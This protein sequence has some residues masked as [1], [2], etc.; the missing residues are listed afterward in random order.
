MRT[1]NFRIGTKL[2]MTAGVGVILVAGMLGNEIVGNQQIAESTFLVTVNASNRANAQAADTAIARA[3]IAIREIESADTNEQL[4]K[5]MAG[6][7][8]NIAE[9][10]TQIEAAA[11]RATRQVMRDFYG[12]TRT[13][14]DDYL[15]VCTELAAVQ[16][17]VIDAV[18]QRNQ[19]VVVWTKAFDQLSASPALAAASNRRD[20][21]LMLRDAL[22]SFNAAHGAGWRF[23]VTSDPE[24]KEQVLRG[25]DTAIASLLRAKETA[26][27]D[28]DIVA[29]IDGLMAAS[30]GF[31]AAADDVVKREEAKAR[32]RGEKEPAIA[33]TLRAN[34]DKAV[35]VAN[36]MTAKRQGELADEITRVSRVGI[37]VGLLVVVVLI[38]AAVFSV[39]GVARPIRRIGDVLLQLAK[40]NDA[41]DIPYAGRGDEI[42]D[43]ARAARTFR[44]NVV[45]RQQLAETIKQAAQDRDEQ[46][47]Q[48]E[49][50]VA[51]F[52]ATADSLLGSVGQNAAVMHDT[53][54]SLTGLAGTAT[55]QAVAAAAASEETAANVQTVAAATE[56]LTVSIQEIGR[57]VEQAT[58]VVRNAGVTTD[59]SA[60]EIEKLAAS[61][62]RIGDV[63][64]LIQAIAAQTNLLALN[65]TIEAARA[66]E[67]GRGFAVVASEVKSLASQTAKAT[68]EIAQQVAGIQASTK[69]AVQA[70]REVAVAMK[71]INEVTTAIAG[72]VE[73]QGA[74]TREISQNV[75]MASQG[76]Q[77]LSSNIA[78]V[79]GAI[80]ETNRSAV[81]VRTASDS[82]TC[83]ANEL[84]EEVKRFFM[85]LRNSTYERS[86]S[87]AAGRHKSVTAPASAAA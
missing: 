36:E 58:C 14:I 15:A 54:H 62:Q 31:R 71:E 3:R 74:A 25:A 86:E 64:G 66:G 35:D 4:A 77:S 87:E 73:E 11:K 5:A 68:E 59:R 17:T 61:G 30:R 16:K 56:E 79:N 63:V 13:L 41:V 48:M 34:V 40:G 33:A 9:A 67:A 45:E 29:A 1:F 70:V 43:A 21:E 8:A 83:Q 65:A 39:L 23:T 81:S 47:R 60:A 42:G 6:M 46:A 78:A 26:S 69:G 10:G 80:G 49:I 84:A 72:A 20:I 44:D 27:G 55:T 76:T 22:A 57:R 2:G 18:T 82:V 19:A 24:Q 85:A 52:R 28:K 51:S 53:A 12:Q 7:R 38:G 50:A 32:L 37:A 75:Q